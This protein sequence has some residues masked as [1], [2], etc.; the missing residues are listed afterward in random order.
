MIYGQKSEVAEHQFKFKITREGLL[1]AHCTGC[2]WKNVGEE[3]WRLA[4]R[5]WG[6]DHG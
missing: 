4:E 6:I 3:T 1:I 2:D 5:Q